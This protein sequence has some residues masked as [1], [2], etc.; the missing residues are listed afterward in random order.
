MKNNTQKRPSKD[1]PLEK[2][3][4]QMD[5]ASKALKIDKSFSE[6]DHG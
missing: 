1:G 3:C 5:E 2:K 6:L 4:C